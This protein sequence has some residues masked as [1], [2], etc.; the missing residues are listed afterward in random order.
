MRTVAGV[1]GLAMVLVAGTTG[2]A[3]R[4]YME[5]RSELWADLYWR[6][7]VRSPEQERALK[8]KEEF[9]GMHPMPR[10]GGRAPG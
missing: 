6:H 3:N 2:W 7:M 9:Q 5:L 10:D 8:P 1:L 4:E